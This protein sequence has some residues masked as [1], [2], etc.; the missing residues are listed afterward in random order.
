MTSYSADDL[1]RV[2]PNFHRYTVPTRTFG[3]EFAI[4]D[5]SAT[6]ARMAGRDLSAEAGIETRRILEEALETVFWTGNSDLNWAGFH[7]NAAISNSPLG[8]TFE[9]RISSDMGVRT[10][11]SEITKAQGEI[12]EASKGRYLPDTLVMPHDWFI[13]LQG[14]QLPN[15]TLSMVDWIARSTMFS[16]QT[17]GQQLRIMSANRLA[18][19]TGNGYGDNSGKA[20]MVLYAHDP[21][22]LRFH[23]PMPVTAKT[24]YFKNPRVLVTELWAHCG[25]LEVLRPFAMRYLTDM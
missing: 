22:V 14:V 9:S 1:P 8:A 3:N 12:Y 10:L 24:P 21:S 20:R 6:V 18:A 19:G 23:L 5:Q 25:G 13:Q 16:G 2:D 11:I 17:G 7:Q 4:D 15:T